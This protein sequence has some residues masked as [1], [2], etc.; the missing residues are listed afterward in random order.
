M[1]ILAGPNVVALPQPELTQS[2]TL[3]KPEDP[4]FNVTI[5]DYA[6]QP[7]H[8][9]ITTGTT[10]VWTYVASGMSVHTVTSR[11][12]T[13]TTQGGAPLLNSGQISPGQSYRYTFYQ[14]G[15][16]PYYCAFHP[17]ITTMN[18]AWVNATGSPITPPSNQS[19][20][21]NYGT[22]ALYASLTVAAIAVVTAT[23]LVRKKRRIS[24]G[25][26]PI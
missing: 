14:P 12:G 20:Q 7:I 21:A 25:T 3:Y 4:T 17:T 13:N 2:L 18:S 26:S 9:N 19:P 1:I 6:F 16:Y 23:L 8:I 10:V 11:S 22:V 5:V 15:L 24:T